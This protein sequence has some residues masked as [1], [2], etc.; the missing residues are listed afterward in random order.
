M[1]HFFMKKKT[2]ILIVV[3][4]LAILIGV[5]ALLLENKNKETALTND[6]LASNNKEQSYL[7]AHNESLKKR[8]DNIAK[9]INGD[10][11]K[12]ALKNI[13]DGNIKYNNKRGNAYYHEDNLDFSSNPLFNLSIQAYKYSK[14]VSFPINYEGINSKIELD[15]Q[16]EAFKAAN[17][18][19]SVTKVMGSTGEVDAKIFLRKIG[20]RN[21]AIYDDFFK[22]GNSWSRYYL[23][24]DEKKQ[25][26]VFLIFSFA[27][28]NA[29]D[30]VV[31]Y[32]FDNEHKYFE[33]VIYPEEVNYYL[34]ILEENI[35]NNAI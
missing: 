23:T 33:N 19:G 31:K 17:K 12:L 29:G 32:D 35:V 27:Y 18:E 15:N 24:Y 6:K 30:P 13:F 14:G 2:T 22:P 10:D 28:Y 16:V 1:T 7:S 9:S 4:A 5:G 26:I 21:F 34:G 20:N 8:E 3:L 11:L 25:Q